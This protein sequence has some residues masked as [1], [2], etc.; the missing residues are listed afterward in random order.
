MP[1]NKTWKA[2]STK[3][4]TKAPMP[5]VGALNNIHY[6]APPAFRAKPNPFPP[7]MRRGGKS[8][9]GSRKNNR[10][11]KTRKLFGGWF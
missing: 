3:P 11:N 7:K 9:K 2:P 6:V 8:R 4:R 5:A 1:N 10:K